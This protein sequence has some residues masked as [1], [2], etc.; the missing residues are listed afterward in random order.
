MQRLTFRAMGCHMLAILDSDEPANMEQLQQVQGWFE[1]W[2]QCLSRF[3]EN[4]ELSRLNRRAGRQVQLSDVLWEVLQTACD[5]AQWSGGLVAPTMLDA[6]EA[7]GYD[8]SFEALDPSNAPE[9]PRQRQ[10]GSNEWRDIEWY[11]DSH[12]VCLPPG[13]RLD[14]GGIAKGWAADEAARR[15]GKVAPTMIDAG[16]DIAVTGPM[17]DGKG[18]PVGVADPASPADTCD[19]RPLEL[20][21]LNG[22]GVATSGRDY[23]RWQFK[24]K[25]QHHIIDPRTGLPAETDVL[26][27]TVL[28]PTACEA[29][30]GAKAAL[31]LGSRDGL[32]W[33]EAR[34]DMAGLLVLE[35]GRVL[36]SRRLKGYLWSELEAHSG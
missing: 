36:R 10:F 9:R 30:V 25:W 27:A 24:G 28:A 3:R 34:Q 19:P 32:D 12:S 11:A 20:L 8:R 5:A 18:W 29:E 14:L 33:L 2:E 21:M 22:G 15:M 23:R 4:S 31:I 16:G 7:A 6:L 17:S 1:E 26:A 13:L 35:D